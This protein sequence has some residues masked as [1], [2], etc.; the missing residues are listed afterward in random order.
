VD[1]WVGILAGAVISVV[2]S[3]VFYRMQKQPKTLDYALK[4]NEIIP[5][6]TI[7]GTG[8]LVTVWWSTS[9]GLDPN[10]HSLSASSARQL[11]Q[12]AVYEY[13][14]QN[15]GKRAVEKGEF[16]K[17]VTVTVP[18]GEIQYVS[19]MDMSSPDIIGKGICDPHGEPKSRGFRPDLLN[20]AEWIDIQVVTDN[21]TQEP[22][23][24][25]RIRDETRPMRRRDGLLE[26]PVRQVLRHALRE[27]FRSA[28]DQ[29]VLARVS[30]AATALS[31]VVAVLALV[32][33]FLSSVR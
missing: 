10:V 31:T 23:L 24:S 29:T 25:A 19:V 13:R 8:L 4:S 20:P 11:E 9:E 5:S 28:A 27:T 7:K 14:I 32:V 21:S 6:G 22:T 3:Y 2:A 1:T 33:G 16:A 15:T 12:P 17:P 26:P 30:A 18:D